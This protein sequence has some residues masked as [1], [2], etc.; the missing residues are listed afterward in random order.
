[1]SDFQIIELSENLRLCSF[2][3]E[4]IY[5]NIP[6]DDI[7]NIISNTINNDQDISKDNQY[8]IIQILKSIL[9]QNY[10]HKQ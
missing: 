9:E 4:N 2:D 3:V 10:L 6:K 1:M 7:I 5:T 8:Q